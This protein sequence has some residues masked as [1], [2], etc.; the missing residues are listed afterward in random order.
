MD[1]ENTNPNP[2]DSVQKELNVKNTK[3]NEA[4]KVEKSD[5]QESKEKNDMPTWQAILMGAVPGAILGAAGILAHEEPLDANNNG[6][7][8]NTIN[9]NNGGEGSHI[10]VPEGTVNV[11]E[12][13]D[14]SMSFAEAFK[15]ARAEVGAGG[16]FT[17]HGHVYSTYYKEEW[18]ELSPEEQSQYGHA[19]SSSD[20]HPEPWH[21]DPTP[22][23]DPDP[24]PVPDPDPTP[25]PVP[26][27]EGVIEIHDVGTVETPIGDV[28]VAVGTVDSHAAIF[29]DVDQDDVIDSVSVDVNDNGQIDESENFIPSEDMHMSDLADSIKDD[30][31]YDD[32]LY[33]DTPDY[34]N[35][36]PIDDVGL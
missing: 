3:L 8:G 19:I 16:A 14:D 21:D 17:W 10:P 6:G 35:D 36:A 28:D 27:F 22:E 4:P 33:P 15:E 13:V 25:D 23:P 34:T 5:V 30:G 26:D 18:A 20:I 29:A 7:G 31:S 9:G 1:T 32:A 24:T 12:G 11:A 2:Q